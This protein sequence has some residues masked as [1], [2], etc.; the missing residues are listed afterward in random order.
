VHNGCCA[1]R[2]PCGLLKFYSPIRCSAKT[3]P[4][5]ALGHTIYVDVKYEIILRSIDV[6][7]GLA[8]RF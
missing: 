7:I 1:V 8:V 4:Q 5:R 6:L 3:Q 2:T